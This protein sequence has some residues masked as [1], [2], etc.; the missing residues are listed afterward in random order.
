VIGGISVHV[1]ALFFPLAVWALCCSVISQGAIFGELKEEISI[2]STPCQF[3][4]V[5]GDEVIQ[6]TL[7]LLPAL[8]KSGLNDC[9]CGQAVR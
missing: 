1:S 3:V 5:L 4:W 6:L 2:S 9:K 8:F 7:I